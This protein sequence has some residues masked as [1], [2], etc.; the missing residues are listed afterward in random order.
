VEEAKRLTAEVKA[1]RK[2]DEAAQRKREAEEKA[3]ATKTAAEKAAAEKAAVAKVAAEK[4]VAEKAAAGKAAEEAKH[5]AAERQKLWPVLGVPASMTPLEINKDKVKYDW[6]AIQLAGAAYNDN[7]KKGDLVFKNNPDWKVLEK[8]IDTKTGFLAYSF[9]NEKEHKIVIAIQGSR[10]PLVLLTP[11]GSPKKRDAGKDWSADIA[12]ITGGIIP[13]QFKTAQQYGAE[14]KARYG[15][16]YEIDCSGHSMGGGACVYAASQIAG[17]HA[18]ALNPISANS[19]PTKNAYV[20][21][22]Y[23]V[24][25]DAADSAHRVFDRGQTGWQYSVVAQNIPSSGVSQTTPATLPLGFDP[26]ARHSVDRAINVL[27]Q[28]AGLQRYELAE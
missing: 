7:L 1:K 6:A 25:Q 5:I 9:L 18:V 28:D 20:I 16:Q 2:V 26:I 22:N 14:I 27:G 13:A 24:P 19:I 4:A 11:F 10:D 8:K 3:A 23:I 12:A 15:A 17:I 21:D